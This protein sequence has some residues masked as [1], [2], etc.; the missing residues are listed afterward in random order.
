LEKLQRHI[1]HTIGA[2]TGCAASCLVLQRYFFA[3][4]AGA[5]SACLDGAIVAH[6]TILDYPTTAVQ[7]RMG[8][9][10]KMTWWTAPALGCFALR[11]TTEEKQPDG[12]FH[13]VSEKRALRVNVQ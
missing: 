4:A 11:I 9:S 7:P 6:E 5:D 13:L 10:V 12:A 2:I 3:R 8:G 1:P